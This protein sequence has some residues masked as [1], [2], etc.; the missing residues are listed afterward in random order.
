MSK[1]SL[2]AR[3]EKIVSETYADESIEQPRKESIK[4]MMTRLKMSDGSSMARTTAATYHANAIAKFRE[5]ENAKALEL[6]EKGKP[7][8]SVFKTKQGVVQ[9]VGLFTKKKYA[10]A[11]NDHFRYG[12]IEKGVVEKGQRVAA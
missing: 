1:L 4:R 2:A 5:A 9:S 10:S 7:V 12:E 11:F 6:A 3:A 8:W